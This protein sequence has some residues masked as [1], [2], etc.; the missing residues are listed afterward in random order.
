[1]MIGHWIYDRNMD[2]VVDDL[3]FS[4]CANYIFTS[5]RNKVIR[6]DSIV[7]WHGSPQQNISQG[8]LI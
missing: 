4:F 3:C 7:G 6:E 1:M 8:P 5:G 2:A